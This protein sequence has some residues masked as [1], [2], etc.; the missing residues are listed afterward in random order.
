MIMAG[1]NMTEESKSPEQTLQEEP[2]APAPKKK[3]KKK[4]SRAVTI[5]IDVLIV[6]LIGVMA[7]SGY[8]LFTTWKGYQDNKQSQNKVS[9]IFYAQTSGSQEASQISGGSSSHPTA[10][11]MEAEFTLEPLILQN[12]D[13]VGWIRMEDTVI[14][15]VIVQGVDN[16][17]YLR[18]DFF[19]DYS[20]GGTVFLDYENVLGQKLQNLIIYGHR[21]NDGSMFDALGKLLDEKFYKEHPTFQLL[22]RNSMDTHEATWYNCE[23][24][25]VYQCTTDVEYCVPFF[26]DYDDMMEYAGYC[27]ARS[28]YKSDIALTENDTI[29]TL[30]TCDY[31]LDRDRGRL[32]VHAKLTPVS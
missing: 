21:M 2:K 31:V 24:F 14:D 19:G 23:I 5:V 17:Q 10:Q 26:S 6:F 11:E 28:Q 13:T 22:L 4:N 12:D 30:S 1:N 27:M 3:R 25:A 15:Y 7:F 16:D 8:Q 18:H 9:D 29:V 32:V 20:V